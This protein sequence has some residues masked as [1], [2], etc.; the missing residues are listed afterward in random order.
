MKVTLEQ[1][2]GCRR[3]LQ[4]EVAPE[5]VNRELDELVQLYARQARVPGFRPGKTPAKLVERRFRKAITDDARDRLL[6]RYYQEALKQEGVTALQ[7]VDVS[8]KVEVK[9]D[10]PLSFSVTVD[11]PPD[12]DLPTYKGIKVK[13]V[14]VSVGDEDVDRY[15]D[16]L[17]DR[18][19]TFEDADRPVQEGDYVSVTYRATLDGT[20]LRET[21]AE[22]SSLG[23]AENYTMIVG[24]QEM[25][26]GLSAGLVGATREETR[27][28]EVTFPDDFGVEPMQGKSAIYET[29]VHDIRGPVRP[30]D[31]E[32][33]K[34]LEEESIEALRATVREGMQGQREQAEKDR[35]RGELIKQVSD[36]VSVDIPESMV[37]AEQRSVIQDIVQRSM[38]Q[39]ASR[40]QLSE[41]GDEIFKSAEQTSRDRVKQRF[42]LE[43]I[44]EAE[45]I[46]VS[47]SDVD[48]RI[49]AMAAQYRMP[50]ERVR[51]EIGKQEDGVERLKQDI[52][53]DKAVERL[54]ELADLE[55]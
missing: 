22:P 2:E 5:E 18:F 40:D 12:F 23:E 31:E 51:G 48:A 44:A 47:D 25:I 52:R 37:Q 27:S 32:L 41:H 45:S 7:V 53:L 46:E 55:S 54:V 4:I 29:T 42:V 43:K 6:P 10:A 39:G 50:P 3:T 26:P 16:S 9:R 13:S 17:R 36:S 14:D 34:Q 21:V 24:E 30:S 20:P 33:A 19:T 49:E 11:V 15:L 28:V 38:A 35:I 1:G 8:D